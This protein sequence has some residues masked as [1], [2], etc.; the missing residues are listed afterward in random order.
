MVLTSSNA[1]AILDLIVD[2]KSNGAAEQARKIYV[3][4]ARAQK[5]LALAIPDSQAKRL[6]DHLEAYGT[7]VVRCDIGQTT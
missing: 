3:G 1:K 6:I 5:L 7:P 4:A 2:A